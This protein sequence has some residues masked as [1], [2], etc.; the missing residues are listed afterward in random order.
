M[1]KE[2]EENIKF[3][4]ELRKKLLINKTQNETELYKIT[5][6]YLSNIKEKLLY[7][8]DNQHNTCN[9][10]RFYPYSNS[11]LHREN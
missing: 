5:Y 8:Y 6:D 2:S 10:F 7:L 9:T 11:N 4:D 3:I 1:N